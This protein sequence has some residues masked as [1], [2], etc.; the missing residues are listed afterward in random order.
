MAETFTPQAESTDQQP[1][2]K[3]VVNPQIEKLLSENSDLQKYLSGNLKGGYRY[4]KMDHIA[5]SRDHA[6]ASIESAGSQKERTDLVQSLSEKLSEAIDKGALEVDGSFYKIE[7]G[8]PYP[9]LNFQINEKKA[10][11]KS[12]SIPLRLISSEK[13]YKGE[14]TKYNANIIVSKSG[15]IF[16]SKSSDLKLENARLVNKS[17]Y[18]KATIRETTYEETREQLAALRAEAEPHE[19]PTPEESAPPE[20]S[21]P[22]EGRIEVAKQKPPRKTSLLAGLFPGLKKYADRSRLK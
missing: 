5:T 15:I 3:E 22:D 4:G 10:E 13:N 16:E 2:H 8:E 12:I 20:P 17:E 1:D 7:L 19:E 21:N 6:T 18:E 11:L 14:S 9:K